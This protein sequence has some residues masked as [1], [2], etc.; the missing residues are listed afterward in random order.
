MIPKIIPPLVRFFFLFFFLVAL[1][2]YYTRGGVTNHSE[3]LGV[4]FNQVTLNVGIKNIDSFK[5]SGKFI[6][7]IP[8]LY[9]IS[10]SIMAATTDT[11]FYV[12]RNNEMIAQGAMGYEAW[13]TSSAVV[14]LH[15]SVN[16]SI[17]VR[18]EAGRQ[19]YG[20]RTC[21]LS[22]IKVK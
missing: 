2:A 16:D 3:V 19:M 11:D 5:S 18:Y 20:G 21:Y 1:T 14:I 8:G 13:F 22:I 4:K 12:F 6:C 15:L 17:W 7:E 10:T 9:L